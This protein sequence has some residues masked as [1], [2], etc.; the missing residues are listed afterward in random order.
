MDAQKAYEAA[1]DHYRKGNDLLHY[2]VA[3]LPEEQALHIGRAAAHFGAGN[4]ALALARA[5]EN[6]LGQDPAS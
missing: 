4:L 2:P 6:G 3:V 5:A 1:L